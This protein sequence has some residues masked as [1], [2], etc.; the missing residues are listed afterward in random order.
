MCGRYSLLNERDIADIREI[1][2]EISKKYPNTPMA[3]G[4]IYPTNTVPILTG[5]QAALSPELASWGFP[6]YQGKGVI[7]NARGET[8]AEKRTFRDSLLARRC[9]VP[10][11]G[12]YEWTHDAVKQKYLF[13]LPEADALYLAGLYQEFK[14]ERRFVILT[15][16]A[17]SSMSQIHDRMPVILPKRLL[18]PWVNDTDMAL[19]YLQSTMPP[20]E[21]TAVSRP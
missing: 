15:T 17:N 8:A 11:T 20:L 2:E 6:K 21:R 1:I 5:G 19:N 10:S 9:A 13:R 4:E 3:H 18:G 14:G 7:I 16:A 12:F